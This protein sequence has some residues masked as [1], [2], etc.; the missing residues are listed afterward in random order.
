MTPERL[1]ARQLA[2]ARAFEMARAKTTVEVPKPVTVGCCWDEPGKTLNLM[3]QALEQF[4]VSARQLF[5]GTS[6]D[7][8]RST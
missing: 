7:T 2:K 6:D 3:E 5:L 1:K 8:L 4:K